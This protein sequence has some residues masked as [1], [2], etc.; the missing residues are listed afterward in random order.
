MP[1]RNNQVDS[2]LKEIQVSGENVKNAP[3]MA[4]NSDA[5]DDDKKHVVVVSGKTKKARLDEN[6]AVTE[7]A[8]AKKT[9]SSFLKGSTPFLCTVLE[10][11][12]IHSLLAFSTVNRSCHTLVDHEK[13]KRAARVLAL[14]EQVKTL[15]GCPGEEPHLYTRANVEQAFQLAA[16]ARELVHSKESLAKFE[17]PL[18]GSE[19]AVRSPLC[20]LPMCFYINSRTM[21][22][23]TTKPTTKVL[24]F[25]NQRSLW[26]WGAEDHGFNSAFFQSE[27]LV[28]VACHMS[29]SPMLFEAFR[30][31]ARQRVWFTR[32]AQKCMEVTLL[33]AQVIADVGFE[34]GM[35][36]VYEHGSSYHNVLSDSTL[37]MEE[38]TSVFDFF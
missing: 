1:K 33:V 25:A 28:P 19:T 5:I 6:A 16:K 18:P 24:E 35:D 22:E 29:E 8:A 11:L 12:D 13:E 38:E 10:Y 27:C 9:V 3:T 34:A 15:V 21:E 14:E 30:A 37:R 20:L 26:L 32:Y 2:S 4:A 23:V 36:W 17:P 7:N 31:A